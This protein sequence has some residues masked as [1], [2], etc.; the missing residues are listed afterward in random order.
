M[1]SESVYSTP[2]SQLNENMPA[3]NEEVVIYAC[4]SGKG[5]RWFFQGIG[6]FAKAPFRWSAISLVNFLILLVTAILSL[7]PIIGSFLPY[8]IYPV[9]V[10]GFM[11]G[12]RNQQQGTMSVADLF[13]GFKHQTGPL[14][15]SGALYIAMNI[16]ILIVAMIIVFA[17]GFGLVSSLGSNLTD[18]PQQLTL[19]IMAAILLFVALTL[20]ALM[21]MWFTPALIIF[22]KMDAITAI[23]FSFKGCMRNFMAY[24]IYGLVALLFIAL[25]GLLV[26]VVAALS[27]GMTSPEQLSGNDLS[28]TFYG[29]TFVGYFVLFLV[30]TPSMYNSVYCSYQDIYQ[31]LNG[32]D[33]SPDSQSAINN[34]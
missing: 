2:Q 32:A 6:L 11:W 1:N 16:L 14:F 17:V 31:P 12:A 24:M 22:N 28:S 5:A 20:P 3:P 4:S 23:K 10:A 25:S 18:N 15:L 33:A 9:I 26:L 30:L 21:A 8:L 7:V 29:I 34:H 27:S 13:A 19:L